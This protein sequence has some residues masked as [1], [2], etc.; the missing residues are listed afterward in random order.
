MSHPS[1]QR[2]TRPRDAVELHVQGIFGEVLGLDDVA[3]EASFLELG[4]HSLIALQVQDRL[5]TE[6]GRASCRERV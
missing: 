5:L 3:I 4:G 2:S 1:E 6:I